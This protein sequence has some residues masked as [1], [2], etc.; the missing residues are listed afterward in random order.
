MGQHESSPDESGAS[1]SIY[2]DVPEEVLESWQHILDE[3]TAR[4]RVPVGL[5]MRVDGRDIE[6]ATVSEGPPP[7]HPIGS[8]EVLAGSGL[9]CER[10]LAQR[11]PLAVSDAARDPDF[12]ENPSLRQHGLRSYLGYPIHWPDGSLFGTICVMDT[13]DRA[14][15][16][17]ERDVM[18]L[19]R[20]LIE[21]N[22]RSFQVR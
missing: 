15:T 5:V 2:P 1:R 10:V 13:R 22:L 19:L 6:V 18:G 4:M 16:E 17:D 7:S 8:R 14:Y 3:M 9:Y 21:A 20:D 12:A 11:E